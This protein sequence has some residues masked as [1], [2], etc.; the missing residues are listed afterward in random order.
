MKKRL[1]N[2]TVQVG[3]IWEYTKPAGKCILL[4][5]GFKKMEV[6]YTKR[7]VNVAV[8]WNMRTNIKSRLTF[9]ATFGTYT[10]LSR[11]E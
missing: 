9:R 4:V 5:T 8:G 6:S 10:L 2:Y 3:D 11:L 7:P 1:N